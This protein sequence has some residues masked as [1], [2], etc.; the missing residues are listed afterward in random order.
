MRVGNLGKIYSDKKLGSII[1]K[2]KSIE[3][4]KIEIY[5]RKFDNT[6]DLDFS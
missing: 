3:F 2:E 1:E 6:L 4:Y 5:A